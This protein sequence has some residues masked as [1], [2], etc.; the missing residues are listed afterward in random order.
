MNSVEH[1]DEQ[2][3][4]EL[5]NIFCTA[6][7]NN[8]AYGLAAIMADDVDYVNI[9]ATLL[10]SREDVEK[11]HLA[12]FTGIM[13]ASVFELLQVSVRF[14]RSDI[15]IV[16]WSWTA[17]GDKDYDGT[18]R[19]RRYGIMTMVAEKQA[20]E[21]KVVAV[22]NTNSVPGAGPAAGIVSPMPI[23]DHAVAKG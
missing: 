9:A 15:A 22:Q 13:S 21:W 23:P 3:L 18:P 12:L 20:E 1:S 17:S 10:H 4:R 19:Q 8:D 5:P 6:V 7:N 11:H 14:L 16:H 2:L